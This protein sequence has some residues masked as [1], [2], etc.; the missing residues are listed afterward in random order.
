MPI[1]LR[2]LM[3]ILFGPPGGGK[4]STSFTGP[5]KTLHIDADRGIDRALQEARPD[6][7]SLDAYK[8]YGEWHN[9]VMS[10]EFETLVLEAGYKNIVL[11]TAAALLDDFMASW[12]ISTNPSNG[13]NG[14][15]ALKGWGVLKSTFAALISRLRALGLNVIIVAHEKNLGEDSTSRYG[16]AVSGGSN[17]ILL[18]IADMVGY[19]H[20]DPKEGRVLDFNPSHIHIGKNTAQFPPLKVPAGGTPAYREFLA[21]L[22]NRTQEKMVEGSQATVE[23][24]AKIEAYIEE[25]GETATAEQYT[26]IVA[27]VKAE[28]SKVIKAQIRP[29]LLA[30]MKHD[31][32]EW[33]AEENKVVGTFRGTEESEGPTAPS[34]DD[35]SNF[36]TEEPPVEDHGMTKEEIETA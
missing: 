24:K 22:I 27:K 18:R 2:A 12:I 21:N 25:L 19:Q 34:A 3:I 32:F 28:P 26:A 29:R 4:T 30:Q 15:L 14:N 1:E 16:L 23:A 31:G 8:D 5:G 20:L 36:P 10:D 35:P 6:Y 7:V 11:D 17:D 13:Y 33:S 9:E